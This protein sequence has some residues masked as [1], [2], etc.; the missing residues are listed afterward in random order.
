MYFFKKNLTVKLMVHYN[1]NKPSTEH[2][3]F[4]S[5]KHMYYN[6]KINLEWFK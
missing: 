3:F 5:L 2:K 4:L 6:I 1:F